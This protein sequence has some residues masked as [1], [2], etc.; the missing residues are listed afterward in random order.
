VLSEKVL[1][2]IQNKNVFIGICMKKERAISPRALRSIPLFTEQVWARDDQFN[3]KTS[4]WI[5]QEIGLAAGLR[6]ELV[7]LVENGVRV[8]GGLQGDVEYI[9]FDR[10]APEQ[11]FGKILEMISALSP[12][13]LGSQTAAPEAETSTPAAQD[14]VVPAGDDTWAVPKDTWTLENYRTAYMYR[15][16][17]ADIAGADGVDS[18]V[19]TTQHIKNEEDLAAWEAHVEFVK[20]FFGKGG[21][22]KRLKKLANEHPDNSAVLDSLAQAIGEYDDIGAADTFVANSATTAVDRQRFLGSA[23]EHYARAEVKDKATEILDRM[24]DDVAAGKGEEVLFLRTVRE[25]AKI[26]K[27]Q[28]ILLG[29]LERI[30][31]LDP[32]NIEARFSLAYEHSQ[33]EN[34]DLA[35]R[36]YYK[37]PYQDRTPISWNNLGVCLAQSGLPVKAVDAYRRAEE[38][39]ETLAMSNIGFKFFGEGFL[40]EAQAQ[41]DKAVKKED[42]EDYDGQVG[43]LIARIKEVPNEEEKRLAEA[44]L[45]SALKSDFYRTFGKAIARPSPA[46]LPIRWQGPDCDLEMSVDGKSTRMLGS[47]ERRPNPIA[48][49]L[50]GSASAPNSRHSLEYAGELNGCAIIADVT[51]RAEGDNQPRRSLLD[52]AGATARAFMIVNEDLTEIRVM[53]NP[54][55]SS[56]TF[57]SLKSAG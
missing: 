25:L 42:K 10:S 6:L 53:E 39:G 11:A 18:A 34:N 30:S 32:S 3:W 28:D 54:Y 27:N 1:S 36:H 31:E 38:L 16:M 14:K 49:A 7:L 41:C 26:S 8:P 57:Y 15:M 13:P 56:P 52:V 48:L 17:S 29:T 55:S 44:L 24:R 19:R 47:F 51:R 46:K 22:L 37:I 23:A 35:L 45:K 21:S 40:S 12:K 20:I 43:A 4:N 2:L 33:S 9:P 5:I 50:T